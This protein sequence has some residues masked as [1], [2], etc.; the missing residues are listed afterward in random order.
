MDGGYIPLYSVR[1]LEV[2]IALWRDRT[3]NDIT[4]EGMPISGVSGVER[5][6]GRSRPLTLAQR[7]TLE[8]VDTVW[9]LYIRED[10]AGAMLFGL[11]HLWGWE[12]A[13]IARA[14]GFTT[15]SEANARLIATEDE[16]MR[17]LLA[18]ES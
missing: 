8:E 9:G 12:V 7:F 15:C 2:L 3:L 16:L 10:P 4:S 5:F 11:R 6:G 13:R 14:V 17:R 18:N 1:E